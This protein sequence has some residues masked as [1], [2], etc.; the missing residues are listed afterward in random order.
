LR[1][2]LDRD[3]QELYRESVLADEAALRAQHEHEL[4][5]EELRRKLQDV[6]HAL[7]IARRNLHESQMQVT[8]LTDEMTRAK[9]NELRYKKKV[10]AGHSIVYVACD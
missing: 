6:R 3:I 8:S 4:Q 1:I 10:Y 9:K 5:E 7:G 2:K